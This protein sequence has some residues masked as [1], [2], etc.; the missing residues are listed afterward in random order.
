MRAAESAEDAWHFKL[1]RNQLEYLKEVK[2]LQGVVDA[3]EKQISLL[4][5]LL[6]AKKN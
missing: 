1:A 2:A 6:N 3:Q 4:T 5:S